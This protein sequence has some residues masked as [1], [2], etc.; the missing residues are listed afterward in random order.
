MESEIWK[1]VYG[2]EGRYEVS[3]TGLVRSVRYLRPM[4]PH[5]NKNGHMSLNFAS[6]KNGRQTT[7]MI[8]R[9]VLSAFVGPPESE[10]SRAV[11]IDG[12][13]G[14]NNLENLKWGK[15]PDD[16]PLCRWGGCQRPR[17]K[18]QYG[19][20][21]GPY[22]TGHTTRRNNGK[23]MDK[24]FRKTPAPGTWGDWGLSRGYRSRSKTSPDGGRERI[25]Q[26]EHRY[27]MEQHLGRDLAPHENVHHKNG[28]RDDNRIENLELWTRKQPAGQRVV[29]RVLWALE[30]LEE[31]G[32]D[33]AVY[34]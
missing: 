33:P 1:P 14:N 23:E 10:N 13:P 18:D 27:V 21:R 28:I 15:R 11:H 17:N 25:R 4:K 26:L 3:N 7:R 9:E 34:E 32:T 22:C 20:F 30:I 6:E 12:N 24:P 5:V 19:H 31:Y 29:D 8:A 2:A 16:D